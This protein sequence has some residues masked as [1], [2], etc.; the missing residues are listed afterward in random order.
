MRRICLTII[1]LAILTGCATAPEAVA[2][3]TVTP[4]IAPSPTRTP[5]PEPT[6][7]PSVLELTRATDPSQQA[8]LS[9]VHAAFEVPIFDVYVERLAIATNLSF[10][11]YTQPSGIVAGD[12]F[13]RVVPNGVRPDAGEVLYETPI[14]LK[15]GDSLLLIFSGP[16]DA[17]LMSYFQQP[18]EP[19]DGSQSRVT[20]IH[21]LPA[22]PEIT[23]QQAGVPLTS[24]IPFGSAGFPI[25]LAPGD[26][27]LQLQSGD[28]TLL[29]YSLNLLERSSYVLIIAGNASD[30]ETLTVIESRNSVPGRAN[31]RAINAAAALGPVDIYLDGEILANTL[32]FTRASDRQFKAA[33]VYSVSVFPAGADRTSVEPLLID[34]VVAN[35]DD[36]IDLLLMGSAQNLRVVTHREDR[37]LLTP[38]DA[39]VS[40]ANTLEQVPSARIETQSEI[41]EEIGGVS[42]GQPPRSTDLSAGLYRFVWV[43]LDG[44]T[45]TDAV[46]IATDIE[47]QPGF[48]YLYLMTGRFGDPPIIFGDNIGIDSNLA[49]LPAGELPTPT[50][51]IPTQ[52]RF[53]NA[54]KGGLPVDVLVDEQTLTSGLSYGN[55]SAITGISPG[56]HTIEIRSAGQT[57]VSL[58]TPLEVST[59]YTIVVFGFGTEPVELLLVD[60]SDLFQGGDPPHVRVINLTMAGELVLG[61]ATSRAE[62]INPE[63]TI[64]SESPQ[65]ESFRRSFAY[66]IDRLGTL[67]ETTGRAASNVALAPLGPHDVHAVDTRLEMIAA[68]FR[69]IDFQPSAHYDIIAFQNLDTMLV[70]GFAV[71]YVSN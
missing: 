32:D 20:I 4:T 35:N 14:T 36:Y 62:G 6:A 70:E 66:G 71:R 63:T 43:Q 45:P 19:L 59:P 21:A 7:L 17:L 16:P 24:P 1:L 68:S 48:S 23:V 65:S 46:E 26:T 51:E 54:I 34:Q 25:I 9:V 13:L 42:Y 38:G 10:G 37:S 57:L 28:T 69:Q 47:L 33:Q 60:D 67:N 22:G 5:P 15:G 49:E 56:D 58:Q 2:T 40:F 50:P 52:V 31:M 3:P 8:F 55:A 12:Y 44:N 30:L 27:T 18:L 53:I 41:L 39:R 29:D 61:L 11:Q 64:F